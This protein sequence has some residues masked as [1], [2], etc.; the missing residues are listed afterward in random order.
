MNYFLPD[1][2]F[3]E[4]EIL[5]KKINKKN[6]GYFLQKLISELIVLKVLTVSKLLLNINLRT[7]ILIRISQDRLW[8]VRE[9]PDLQGEIPDKPWQKQIGSFV[10][11]S[12]GRNVFIF[13]SIPESRIFVPI[14]F[15]N[16]SISI[17]YD[18]ISISFQI[19]KNSIENGTFVSFEF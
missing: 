2:S 3:I 11:H 18:S 10:I 4:I 16:P 15:K 1:S 5:L 8:E 6:I 7:A 13:R 17:N 9:M 14:S 12:K 19:Q